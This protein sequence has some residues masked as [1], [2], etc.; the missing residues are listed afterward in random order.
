MNSKQSYFM[1]KL[2]VILIYYSV[3][4]LVIN[5]SFII[6]FTYVRP[7]VHNPIKLTQRFR[8]KLTHI[9]AGVKLHEPLHY[10]FSVAA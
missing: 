1:G 8:R 6:W 7:Q 5:Y 3:Y 10:T 9:F 4:F 2:M